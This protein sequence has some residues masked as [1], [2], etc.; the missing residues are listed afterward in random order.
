MAHIVNFSVEGLVG[1]KKVFKAKLNRD[2]NII[3]GLNG[4]G[5]TSLLRILDS[6]MRAEASIVK[7]VPFLKARVDVYSVDYDKI[8]KQQLN[9]KELLSS[10]SEVVTY[11]DAGGT[12]HVGSQAPVNWKAVPNPKRGLQGWRHSFLPDLPPRTSLPSKLDL[13]I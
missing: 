3:F 9:R 11:S 2:T 6:A 5:K 1:R 4:S 13:G 8:F 10:Q 7:K 12:V